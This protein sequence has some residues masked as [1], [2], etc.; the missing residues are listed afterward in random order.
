MAETPCIQ[1]PKPP[2]GF[3]LGARDVH[4]WAAP[5]L[6]LP[7]QTAAY[8]SSLSPDELTRAGRFLF[9]RDRRRFIIGRGILRAMLGSYLQRHPAQIQFTYT[10]RGKPCLSGLSSNEELHFNLAHSEELA[11]FAVSRI[12]GIGID[13][14]KLRPMSDV[15]GIAE[16][17][18]SEHES[19]QLQSLPAPEKQAGFFNL[20]TRKEA[21]LKA[22]GEGIG[23]MLN[24]VEVSLRPGEPARLVSI[25]NDAHA[26]TTWSLRELIPATGYTGALAVPATDFRMHC[27]SWQ[28]QTIPM[29]LSPLPFFPHVQPNEHR[30]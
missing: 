10:Q 12:R 5:L 16:R 18:F 27:W 23:E 4:V 30:A 25:F 14:E 21:W 11:I 20:W 29:Q 1:W 2:G 7:E 9:E 19:R 24:Q 6:M 22:T 26:A 8:E 28:Q 17:F 15:E 13:V 3:S